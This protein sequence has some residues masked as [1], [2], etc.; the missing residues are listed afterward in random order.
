[1]PLSVQRR[2]VGNDYF[3]RSPLNDIRI[4]VEILHKA[5][6]PRTAIYNVRGIAFVLTRILWL[7]STF[8]CYHAYYVANK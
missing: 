1:M 2:L 8:I 4:R 6:L 3:L 7:K 5:Q